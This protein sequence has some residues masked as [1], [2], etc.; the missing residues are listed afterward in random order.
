MALGILLYARNT[1]LT[2][3][4]LT[5]FVEVESS[6]AGVSAPHDAFT[7]HASSAE[8]D[9]VCSI[10]IPRHCRAGLSHSA[11]SRLRRILFHGK[12]LRSSFVTASG[13]DADFLMIHSNFLHS[14]VC[15]I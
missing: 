9:S 11:A 4:W 3:R 13:R 1:N 14:G 5:G 8:A 6:G 7:K 2:A 10:S 15:A 12:C